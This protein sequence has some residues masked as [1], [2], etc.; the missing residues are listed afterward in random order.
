MIEDALNTAKNLD[1]N[2]YVDKKFDEIMIIFRNEFTSITKYKNQLKEE[3]FPLVENAL[4]GQYF[5]KSDIDTL[6]R[7]LKDLR[8]TIINKIKNEN[9]V[10][11][12]EI[13]KKVNEFLQ[14]NLENLNNIN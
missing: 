13:R 14:N 2:E 7:E 5:I 9:N 8:G 3:K 4:N 10:Y 1:E 12:D 11:L 6:S